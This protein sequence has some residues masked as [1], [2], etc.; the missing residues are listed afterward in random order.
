MP[1]TAPTA[2]MDMERRDRGRK[3][4][5]LGI[6]EAQKEE[7]DFSLQA[8]RRGSQRIS[9]RIPEGKEGRAKDIRERVGTAGKLGT[10]RRNV[11]DRLS[12]RS[13]WRAKGLWR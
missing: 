5:D 6:K 8:T 9:E 3:E 7:M 12:R 10:T 11:W 2:I 4:K 13:R 1:G